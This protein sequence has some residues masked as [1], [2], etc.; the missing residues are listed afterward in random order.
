M[1]GSKKKRKVSVECNEIFCRS[2]T[3]LNKKSTAQHQRWAPA[4]FLRFRARERK[5][6]K[7]RE[8]AKKKER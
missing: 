6:K 7:Q 4:L 5:A 3:H 1:P 8:S 2:G